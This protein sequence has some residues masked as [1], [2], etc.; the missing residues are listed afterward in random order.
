MYCLAWWEKLCSDRLRWSTPFPLSLSHRN[1]SCWNFCSKQA[2]VCP[3]CL[4]DMI[5][6]WDHPRD[7]GKTEERFNPDHQKWTY[8][9]ATLW[10]YHF[11][12]YPRSF[13]G[14]INFPTLVPIWTHY[15]ILNWVFFSP[16]PLVS[17][18]FSFLWTIYITYMASLK[19]AD[20][21]VTA[22][23]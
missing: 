10:L 2:P 20:V 17:N 7:H 8:I 22:S 13:T 4:F 5:H 14:N 15:L 16:Q 19:K 12:V 1:F 3:N 11:Q 6:R 9:L 18:S 23:S 21:D